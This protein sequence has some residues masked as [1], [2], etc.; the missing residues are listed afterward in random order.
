MENYRRRQII[1]IVALV[2][3]LLSFGV[4]FA[5]FSTTLSIKSSAE[6]N[7][8]SGTFN[9]VFSNI[10]NGIDDN[11]VVPTKTPSTLTATNGVINNS[12][13]PVLSN[14]SATFTEPGQKVE[15]DLYVYNAGEYVAYLNS[16]TFKGAKSC[17]ATDANTN[18]VAEACDSITMNVKVAPDTYTSTTQ[19]IIG[20]SL[21]KGGYETV[22]VTIEYAAN[23]VRADGPFNISFPDVSLYYVTVAG[24]N[25]EYTDSGTQSYSMIYSTSIYDSTIDNLDD[26]LVFRSSADLNNFNH[27]EMDGVTVDSTDYIL[28]EGSTNVK[29]NNQYALA[30][31]PG[32][33]NIKIVSNDGYAE[34]SF[35][36]TGASR[37]IITFSIDY[38]SRVTQ[39]TASA[40]MNWTEWVLSYGI[41]SGDNGI[42]CF[43]D[44]ETTVYIEDMG[45]GYYVNSLRGVSYTDLIIDGA[46]YTIDGPTISFEQVD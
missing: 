30:L 8:N 23:G 44:G 40:G 11:A 22:K 13:S 34:A 43:K 6:V 28:S 25:E 3:A 46:I 39:Y 12:S 15:Y 27:V 9:V 38:G 31:S 10:N 45:N 18:Y 20:H 35:Q 41:S 37:S 42:V 19:N 32:E 17:T 5:A 33:H 1:I 36:K 16:V 21:A 26:S 14:L 4:G 2:V 29:F 7:P 24:V